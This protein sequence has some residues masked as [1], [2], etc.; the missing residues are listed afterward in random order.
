MLIKAFVLRLISGE[1]GEIAFKTWLLSRIQGVSFM[2]GLVRP[3]DLAVPRRG[4]PIPRSTWASLGPQSPCYGRSIHSIHLLAD[5]IQYME[6]PKGL[7]C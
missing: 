6:V 5:F 7:Q 4:Q 1:T 2:V 3:G